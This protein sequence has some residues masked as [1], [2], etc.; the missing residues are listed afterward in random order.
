MLCQHYHIERVCRRLI[1]VTAAVLGVVFF[2][3]VLAGAKVINYSTA[4]GMSHDRVQGFLQDSSGMMW[5]CTWYGI[6]RFD[7]YKFTGFRPA[8]EL[9]AESRFKD[10]FY[11]D[12]TLFI[13]TINGTVLSF[14][15]NT[16]RFDRYANTI[17]SHSQARRLR[18]S[19]IDRNGNSWN[20]TSSGITLTIE[21][22]CDYSIMFNN[23][24]PYP[25]A[26]FEDSEERI[27]ISWCAETGDNGEVKVYDKSGNTVDI[28][29]K[30]EQVY[31]I[32]E[33]NRKNV[34]LG[35]RK[36]GLI[37]L[38]PDKYGSYRRYDYHATTANGHLSN[39]SVF[40]IMQDSRGRVW[41]AT[42][43]GGVNY[44]EAEYDVDNLT[45]ILPSGYP[46]RQHKRVRSLLEHRN[47]IFIGTD[48]GILQTR[49]DARP[50]EMK[51]SLV[52]PSGLRPA[53]ETIHLTAWTDTAFLVSSFGKGILGYRYKTGEFFAVAAGDY[54]EKQPVFAALSDGDHNIWVTTRTGILLYDLSRDN[55]VVTPVDTLLTI[56]E[57]KP[58]LDRRGNA[59]FGSEAGSIKVGKPAA[60]SANDHD[61]AVF[62]DV[63]FFHGDS[64]VNKILTQKDSVIYVEPEMRDISLSVT[65]LDFGRLEGV[66]YYWRIIEE[67][68][69]WNEADGTNYLTVANLTPGRK[70]VEVCSTDSYGR[71]LDNI[72]RVSLIVKPRWHEYLVFRIVAGAAVLI[73]L[74]LLFYLIIRYRH[75]RKIYDSILNSSTVAKVSAAMTEIKPE[76]NLTEGDNGFIKDL[77]VRIEE[78]IGDPKFSIDSIVSA[79]GMS[80]SVFYR[81]LKSVVGQSPSEYI[82]KY[83][84]RRA[85]S[86]LSDNP[87]KSVASVAYECGFSSPQYFSNLFRKEYQMTPN[88]W[89]KNSPVNRNYT[90]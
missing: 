43:G 84:L 42:L 34:W 25:R 3:S 4:D 63:T 9:N 45:F 73:I 68:T 53:E 13:K 14:D 67:D 86:M 27:W 66:K 57:T 38:S 15:L 82:N 50:E 32:M 70:T 35:T 6:D 49:S 69:V 12:D 2:A 55:Y 74:I 39:N 90:N 81:R 52:S 7:G 80:R 85:A 20:S 24:C 18:R 65:S 77:N 59:W 33:D 17:T 60:V 71:R 22:Q 21:S 40:D 16:C 72:G 44:V 58:I 1:A 37:I 30:G 41:I 23:S 54:A 5:I 88:E 83:R 10:V 76:E 36:N 62:T 28:A 56:L 47:T 87:D 48:T 46:L 64:T 75:L 51:F 29:L 26:F 79:M 8:K 61:K 31:S 19:F 78:M 89:R 11:A